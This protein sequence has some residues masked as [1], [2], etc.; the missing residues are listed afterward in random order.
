MFMII[1]YPGKI[2]VRHLFLLKMSA[3]STNGL[4]KAKECTPNLMPFYIEYD[5]QA[6]VSTYMEVS[7]EKTTFRGRTMEGT[8]VEVGPG[9]TGLVME[10]RQ[11]GI[12]TGRRMFRFVQVWSSDR[13]VDEG[14][15]EYVRS[16]GEWT[17]LADLVSAVGIH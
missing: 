13:G 4:T 14:R 6:P 11:E 3:L 9:Y 8:K 10:Q 7:G 5:G 15:D 1:N 16:L 2:Q 12:V 17:A